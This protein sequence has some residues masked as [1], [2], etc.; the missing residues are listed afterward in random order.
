MYDRFT[1]GAIKV[2]MLAQQEAR[3]L[4]HESV[5]TE[6]LLVALIV[7]HNGL[8]AKALKGAGLKRDQ[9][10]VEVEKIIGRGSGRC[11]VEIPFTSRA[12]IIL[13][14]A[15]QKSLELGDLRTDTEHLLLALLDANEGTGVRVLENLDVDRNALF[16]N[17]LQLRESSIRAQNEAPPVI[18]KQGD[19]VLVLFESADDEGNVQNKRRPM[20]VISSDS[21]NLR[22]KS[23]ALVPLFPQSR[24][25]VRDPLDV[26]ISADSPAGQT[27]GLRQDSFVACTFVYTYPRA[28]L[29]SKIGELPKETMNQICHQVW[30]FIKPVD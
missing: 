7:E 3:R 8:A 30:D 13:E 14:W 17:I 5:G 15:S 26:L 12:T 21:C 19:V 6:M 29:V 25:S 11:A 20:I 18:V 10:R 24:E 9:I 4:G 22:L 2:V 27:G 23:I 28:W 1:E 16:Q